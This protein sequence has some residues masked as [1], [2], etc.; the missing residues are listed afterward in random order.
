MDASLDQ[1]RQS[2]RRIDLVFASVPPERDFHISGVERIRTHGREM[3]VFASRNTEAII[4]RA[5]D[6]DAVS[7]EV[8]PVGLRD[9]FLET[10]K[11][12]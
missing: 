4:A 7:V 3:S 5:R 1:L 2:Y 9:I 12:N 6:F 10:V 8:A 11:E